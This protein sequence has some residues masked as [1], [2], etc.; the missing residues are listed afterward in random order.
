MRRLLL[1]FVVMIILSSC[2]NKSGKSDKSQQ[3]QMSEFDFMDLSWNTKK[4]DFIKKEGAPA[5]EDSSF[6]FYEKD[7][8]GAQYYLAYNFK[9]NK[10]VSCLCS[11]KE[12][13]TSEPRVY[14]NE[15]DKMKMILVGQYNDP[16][17]DSISFSD[18]TYEDDPAK[19][20]MAG[21]VRMITKWASNRTLIS[22]YLEKKS[23][24]KPDLAIY[25]L[26]APDL[27]AK[28]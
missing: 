13:F 26:Y 6:L 15:Y 8:Q 4:I 18:K 28:K 23:G 20:L 3:Y 16:F 5:A 1:F 14:I 21:H 9:D 12:D 7:I 11:L 19:A 25:Y 2:G 10:L 27:E 22:L 24:K 17:S